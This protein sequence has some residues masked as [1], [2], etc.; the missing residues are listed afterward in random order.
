MNR[1]RCRSNN[2]N[3]HGR[4]RNL[5]NHNRNRRIRNLNNSC[6]GNNNIHNNI[7]N[8]DSNLRINNVRNN[9]HQNFFQLYTRHQLSLE[10]LQ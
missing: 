8:R 2:D 5:N 4:H 9:N 6:I 10:V 1:G 7:N 3:R